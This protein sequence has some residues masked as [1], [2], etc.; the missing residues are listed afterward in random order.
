MK[1]ST[2]ALCLAALVM[3]VGTSLTA[4]ERRY[5]EKDTRTLSETIPFDAKRALIVANV[6][7]SIRVTG[8]SG[9]EIRLV[10]VERIS[11]RT[12]DRIE[13]A[14][15]E[16]KLSIHETADAVVICADGPF[17]EPDDCTEWRD[18]YRWDPRYEVE[19][20]IELQVPHR[21]ELDLHT[22]QG[23]INVRDVDGD[24]DVTGVKGGIEMTRI[25]GSGRAKTVNGPVRVGFVGNP[26]SDSDFKTINGEIDITFP[27][28][29][30]AD[31]SFKTMNG[32]IFTDFDYET[33][34][35]RTVRQDDRRGGTAFRLETRTSIRVASGGPQF[36]FE[37]IN[38]DIFVRR[39]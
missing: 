17:R 7:G 35:P 13:Q 23:D 20:E 11:A 30:S 33:L 15:R 38:G 25:A 32:D 34:P 8:A 21:I 14:R 28:G 18:D 31:M 12:R 36:H 10:A 26:E 1:R 4:H 39:D 27:P 3:L 16:V 2:M 22:I 6:N 24:F 19:Y 9:S 37:N 5:D 29:L